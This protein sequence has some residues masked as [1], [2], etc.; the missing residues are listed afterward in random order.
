MLPGAQQE[1]D[2]IMKLIP[3]EHSSSIRPSLSGLLLKG[4]ADFI[5]R[6]V[7]GSLVTEREN[8]GRT[9]ALSE[10]SQFMPESLCETL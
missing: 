7:M 1:Y 2:S 3:D 9:E 5:F 8:E 6:R 10:K 4:K